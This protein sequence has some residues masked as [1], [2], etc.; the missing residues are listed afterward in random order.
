MTPEQKI[1]TVRDANCC[2]RCLKPGHKGASCT[3]LERSSV[4]G[5]EASHHSLLHGTPRMF[6]KRSSN[7]E[8]SRSS[9]ATCRPASEVLFNVVPV[10]LEA[11]GKSVQTWALLDKCSDSSLLDHSLAKQLNLHGPNEVMTFNTVYGTGE[12][13]NCKRVDFNLLSRDAKFNTQVFDAKVVPQL[14]IVN[15][16]SL[17]RDQIKRWSHLSDITFPPRPERIPLIIGRDVDVHDVVEIRKPKP[18]T[19]GPNAERTLF[20]WCIVGKVPMELSD[21]A[22]ATVYFSCTK[23]R[24]DALHELV[25]RFQTTES[26]GVKAAELK[27]SAEE[28]RTQAIFNAT[29]R[30]LPNGHYESGLFWKNDYVRWPDN[31]SMAF[32]A[33]LRNEARYATDPQ[34]ADNVTIEM[35]TLVTSGFAKKLTADQLKGPEGKT[36]YL[37]YH[38]VRHPAKPEK[39][40]MV[41]DASAVH[42]GTSLNKNLLKGPETLTNLC[43][44]ILRFRRHCVPVSADIAKMFLQV[45]VREEDQSALRYLWRPPGSK[46]PPGVYQMLVHIFGA[47]CSPSICCSV[48]RKIADDHAEEFSDIKRLVYE[49][50][51]VDNYL[52]SAAT[53]D[54]AIQRIRRLILLLQRGGY[55]LVKVLSS[56]REVMNA[57]RSEE[58]CDPNLDLTRDVLPTVRTM[59]LLWNSEQDAFHFEIENSRAVRTKR[60]VLRESSSVYDPLGFI[61]PVMIVA[62]ILI[63]DT[64]RLELSWDE[65]LPEE[66][67]DRWHRWFKDIRRIELLKIPRCLTRS[68]PLR[69]RSVTTT[70]NSLS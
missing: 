18:G 58:R 22:A 33:L 8:T 53:V 17:S 5:C 37:P 56:F 40:R 16:S 14:E 55:H 38:A 45:F 63:Q 41:F 3:R 60:Q 28:I 30:L 66:L 6:P 70:L 25:Y 59:G 35:E 11:N 19:D 27:R 49:N 52:D 51:Y 54:E 46:D 15:R 10:T 7:Q 34:L 61:A 24:D 32:R 23:S 36:W 67:M 31:H 26:F 48:L 4:A 44:N 68:Q 39:V 1:K 12:S 21:R 65:P 62:R 2:Y 13:V 50:F 69:T 64:W 9:Y 43:G 42:E 57:V 29:T 47:V 20:G